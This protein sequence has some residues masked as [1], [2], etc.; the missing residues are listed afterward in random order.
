MKVTRRNLICS[1]VGLSGVLISGFGQAEPT[2][3]E[4]ETQSGLLFSASQAAIEEV[5][6]QVSAPIMTPVGLRYFVEGSM[7]GTFT[8]DPANASPLGPRGTAEAYVG[9][10]QNWT[11]RRRR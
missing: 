3:F 10:S 6:G 1:V 7:N 11:A 2:T 4:W 5:T 8:Y 9:P